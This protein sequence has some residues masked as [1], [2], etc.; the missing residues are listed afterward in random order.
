MIRSMTGYGRV[1]QTVDGLNILFEIKSVN[2]RFF[3]FSSRIPRMYGFIEDKLKTY[4]QNYISR[5]KVD[6]FMTIDSV[7]GEDAQ[8]KLNYGLAKSYIEALRELQS[9]YDL[10]DDISVSTV[11][12]YSDIFTVIKPPDDE[13][14]VWNA[15]KKAAGRA[16]SDFVAMREAEGERLKTDI[17]ARAR[18]VSKLVD[19]VEKRSPETVEEYRQKLTSRMTELLTDAAVDENRI[20]LEAAIYADKVSV[21][22]ETVRLKSHLAQFEIMLDGNDPVGRKLDFLMQEMNREA[23]TIGSKATDVEIAGIVVDI[24]AE[25]E[26]IREQ[27]QNLE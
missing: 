16:L 5:G 19:M 27:I 2:H 4:I 25:L 8:V 23:N 9:K 22:E 21:T 3:D 24:K 6:V 15:V 18:S 20:V 1:Q 14:R 12:R 17:V 10:V 7:N 11:A 13:E 26:K